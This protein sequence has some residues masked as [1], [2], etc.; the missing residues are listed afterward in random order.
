MTILLRSFIGLLLLVLSSSSFAQS[1]T[2]TR[3]PDIAIP[4]GDGMGSVIAPNGDI[5]SVDRWDATGPVGSS[6]HSETW[7]TSNGQNWS[8]SSVSKS[9]QGCHST[10][11]VLFNSRIYQIG[12]DGV[13]GTT[14][15]PA[16]DPR[17]KSWDGLEVG[18]TGWRV[19][20]T[21]PTLNR[22]GHFGFAL[23]G[24]LCFGGGQ[25]FT[26]ITPAPAKFFTD[27][28]CSP[29]GVTWTMVTDMLPA[30]L[31]GFIS[32]GSAPIING[33][34]YLWSGGTYSTSDF[35]NREYNDM[36]SIVA[37][38]GPPNFT[39]RLV[40]A[41]NQM[42]AV[43]YNS[44]A[45][46][47]LASSS[48]GWA[49]LTVAG[50][51]GV[52]LQSVWAS[53]DLGKTPVQLSNFPGPATHAMSIA[54]SANEAIVWGGLNGGQQSWHLNDASKI[55][56]GAA[57]GG[58]TNLGST[59]TICDRTIALTAG[60]TVK[61]LRIYMNGSHAVRPKIGRENSTTNYD[62]VFNGTSATHPGGG[63]ADFSAAN[64]VVPSDGAT[65]RVC[66]AFSFTPGTPDAF[67]YTGNRSQ[68]AGDLSGNSVT[69][70]AQPDSA[71]IPIGWTEY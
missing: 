53:Y 28:W 24:Q 20:A 57:V 34:A 13:G 40:N 70:T 36:Q 65:Y 12:C 55:H 64:Y 8:L 30:G 5:L 14:S 46:L 59:Y 43:L 63:Y 50:H 39:V 45:A 33:E 56:Y 19:D 10:P 71:T 67:S 22:V 4:N 25:T 38:G 16:Y 48:S 60:K 62:F 49:L 35:P 58:T 66:F 42:P 26:S 18:S 15:V 32:S 69:L 6:T 61:W 68:A 9:Y 31:H 23:G 21:L 3:L 51:N 52:N 44:V 2:W 17:V 11:V 29:D 54:V 1:L 41:K 7:R 37:I 27:L 47:P